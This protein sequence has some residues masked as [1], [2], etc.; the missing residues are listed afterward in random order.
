V[1]TT[2]LAPDLFSGWGIRTVSRREIRYNPMSYH[3]G[4][5]WPHDN[6][7]IAVGL[8]QIG[9]KGAV[10]RI[11]SALF[12]AATHM[13]LN[14]LPELFCFQRAQTE[15]RRV[16]RG[17]CA[18]RLGEA[19]HSPLQ[20]ALGLEIDPAAEQ[21]RLRNPRLPKFLD[22]VILRNLSVGDSRRHRGPARRG[23]CLGQRLRALGAIDVC[24]GCG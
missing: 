21:L 5:V 4:S 10:N 8:A 6:A 22:E 23:S 14:R 13:D 15:G 20:A 9:A 18:P 11:F 3:N 1:A 19:A 17:A 12:D 7:L 16:T 2:L 24:S